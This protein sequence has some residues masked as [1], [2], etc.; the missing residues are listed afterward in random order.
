MN[1]ND[2]CC[3]KNVEATQINR[4]IQI[5]VVAL[6]YELY[7]NQ[8]CQYFEQFQP[9]Y[10]TS[11]YPLSFDGLHLPHATREFSTVN[12]NYQIHC[13]FREILHPNNV[14]SRFLPNT[15]D[16]CHNHNLQSILK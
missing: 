4:S 13:L 5:K 11:R 16:L 6:Y 3:C 12:A 14:N 15:D 9:Q 2:E 1:Q 10:G 7:T 8:L